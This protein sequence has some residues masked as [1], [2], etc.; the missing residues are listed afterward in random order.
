[1]S[2]TLTDSWILYL[3]ALEAVDLPRECIKISSGGWKWQ[4]ISVWVKQCDPATTHYFITVVE[5]HTHE[6]SKG[7]TARLHYHSFET[8]RKKHWRCNQRRSVHKVVT[9]LM[10]PPGEEDSGAKENKTV[11]LAQRHV[12]KKES[13]WDA[14][15]IDVLQNCLKQ[16]SSFS[17]TI[18]LGLI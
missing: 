5:N 9:S 15:Q 12:G 10:Q 1:M 6:D 8:W 13:W 17:R 14:V 16:W 2:E 7:E 3:L 11:K 4:W 18:T